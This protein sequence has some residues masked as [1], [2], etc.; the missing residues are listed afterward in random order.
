MIILNAL[1]VLYF[2]YILVT[3]DYVAL[4]KWVWY[5]DGLAFLLNAV[6][7]LNYFFG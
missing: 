6:I 1:F 5:L 3:K 7:V 2:L 4:P